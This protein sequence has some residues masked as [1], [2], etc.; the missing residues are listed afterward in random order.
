MNLRTIYS[1][2]DSNWLVK[3][4]W[5]QFLILSKAEWADQKADNMFKGKKKASDQSAFYFLTE[6][7]MSFKEGPPPPACTEHHVKFFSGKNTRTKND[8]TE[9]L[10]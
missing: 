6:D 2:F 5:K 4:L 9:K 3:E 7:E 10:F 1:S 8:K